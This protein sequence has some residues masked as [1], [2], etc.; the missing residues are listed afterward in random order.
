[1]RHRLPLLV[2]LGLG[3][4]AAASGG[5][6]GAAPRAGAEAPDGRSAAWTP[7][8]A[9][10]LSNLAG[11]KAGVTRL[12]EGRVALVS[13]WATWCEACM[14]EL[15]ALNRLDASTAGGRDAV[16]I[17][18]DVG[19]DPDTVAAFAR[20]RGLRYAQLVDRDFAF[21]DALGQRRVPATLVVDRH[22]RIVYRGDALDARSLE[23]L[24]RAI[25]EAQATPL[26][27]SSLSVYPSGA[28]AR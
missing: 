27:A 13:M 5:C 23:A 20:R 14:K 24:R 6:G 1:M 8:P 15:D 19:E 4:A 17:G 9:V 12:A 21:A 3:L 26:Q 2:A 28:T 18:V 16:V 7:V 11:G 22:G 10:E 25:A